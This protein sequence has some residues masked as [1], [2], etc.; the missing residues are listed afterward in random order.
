[1]DS[2]II[3]YG[4]FDFT[5]SVVINPS[6][7]NLD[8]RQTSEYKL[9][10][11]I[12]DSSHRNTTLY[13]DTNKFTIQLQEEFD[14]VVSM[15]LLM[16]HFPFSQQIVNKYNNNFQLTSYFSST[17]PNVISVNMEIGNYDTVDI[18]A[19]LQTLLNNTDANASYTV[20]YNIKSN[21]YTFSSSHHFEINTVSYTEKDFNGQDDA[22]YHK[23]SIFKHIG[24]DKK[25]FS[26]V[27]NVVDGL[28]YITS[29]F[30]SNKS[31]NEYIVVNIDQFNINKSI[32]NTINSSFVCIN[33]NL[34]NFMTFPSNVVKY[35]QQP[36]SK[37]NKLTIRCFDKDG[38]PYDF[39]N[40]DY[41]MELVVKTCKHPLSYNSYI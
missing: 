13:P 4:E 16:A 26:S 8:K 9:A 19:E 10:R 14:D 40:M 17:S 7:S 20:L 2:K 31:N 38:N 22:V 15:E 32:N 39:S 27:L 33:K 6:V 24:F 1:M 18:A 23:Y 30:Q 3:N 35:L 41:K 11:I 29:P 28:Y 36:M 34:S 25:A 21:K 12:V 5:K 37:L